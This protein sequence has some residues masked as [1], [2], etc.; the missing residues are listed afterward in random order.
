MLHAQRTTNHV[1]NAPM[2]SPL[3]PV[4]ADFERAVTL[5]ALSPTLVHHPGMPCSVVQSAGKN[6]AA[7]FG[8]LTMIAGVFASRVSSCNCPSVNRA[9]PSPMNGMSAKPAPVLLSSPVLPSVTRCTRLTTA[10]ASELDTCPDATAAVKAVVA[11]AMVA[12]AMVVI[13]GT[14]AT[15]TTPI[16]SPPP[17]AS[18][19]DAF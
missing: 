3:Y 17:A 6:V 13:I 1:N 15:T 11:D 9:R 10:L 5:S 16:M 8:A 12:G 2:S 18:G 19:P 4:L 14:I 7:K